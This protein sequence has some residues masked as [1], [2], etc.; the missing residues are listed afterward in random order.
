MLYG[1]HLL[2]FLIRELHSGSEMQPRPRLWLAFFYK[3]ELITKFRTEVSQPFIQYLWGFHTGLLYQPILIHQQISSFGSQCVPW[4]NLAVV[5]KRFPSFPTMAV[6]LVPGPAGSS[7]SS[8]GLLALGCQQA[9]I[10]SGSPLTIV[11]E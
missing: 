9:L 3:A 7:S 11:S 5:D 6:P 2:K 8:E 1:S 4:L 10:T